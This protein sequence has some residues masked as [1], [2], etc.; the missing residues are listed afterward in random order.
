MAE[1]KKPKPVEV[2]KDI[3]GGLIQKAI[4]TFEGRKGKIDAAVDGPKRKK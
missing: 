3:W 2:P 1:D 4:E